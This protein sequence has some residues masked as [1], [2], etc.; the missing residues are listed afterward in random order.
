MAN[1][2]LQNNNPGNLKDPNTGQFHVFKTPEEGHQALLNDIKTKQSGKSSHIKPGA[3]ILALA[4]IWAPASDNNVPKN[5]ANTVAKTVG[6]DLNTPFDKVPAD[7]L[8][9][10]IKVAEGTGEVKGASTQKV[11]TPEEFGQMIKQKHPEYNDM[12]NSELTQKVLA[13]Y[14][15]YHDMV[16]VSQPLSSALKGAGYAQSPEDVKSET[17]KGTLG[18]NPK[19]SLY[20]KLIDNSITRGIQKYG[21]ITG[22][23]KVGQAIGTLGGYGYEKLKG[24]LGGKDNSA[25]Y[26]LSAPSP[27]ATAIDAAR[28]VGSASAIKGAGG[29]L[30]KVFN[31]ASALD[32]PIAQRAIANYIPEEV[33]SQSLGELMGTEAPT[34]ATKL[35][36]LTKALSA[37]RPS[38]VQALQNAI[39]E[40]APLAHTELGSAG[41]AEQFPKLAKVLGFFGNAAGK[42][43]KYGT[44]ATGLGLG[45]GYGLKGLLGQV[46]QGKDLSNQSR[47][48]NQP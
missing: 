38:E 26:D 35:D 48:F 30:S 17:Y 10:G 28:M 36:A 42:T 37:A 22:G 41:F 5:W 9:E 4:N 44:L 39:E 27:L 24:L 40:V 25:N 18:T 46:L 16:N 1:L 33:G 6:V 31:P 20:G 2:G 43:L 19:D 32:N 47:P 23:N 34:A 12:A 15:Q 7:K 21:D 3:S 29:L 14:P 45:A 8:A 13:K 11:Y